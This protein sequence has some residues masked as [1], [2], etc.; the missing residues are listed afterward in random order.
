MYPK[1]RVYTA[2]HHTEPDRVPM[3]ASFVPE[4]IDKLRS[5]LNISDTDELL[6]ELGNDMVM[7]AHGFAAG[8]YASDKEEYYDDWGCKWKYFSNSSGRYPE[9]VQR[10]LSDKSL[11]SSYSIPDPDDPVQYEASARTIQKYGKENWIFG[12]IACTIFECAWGLRGLSELLLDMIEDKDFVHLLM[13]KV[14]EF[15]L[16]AGKKLIDMGVDMLW[17]G[18]DIGMQTGMMI[19]PSQWREFLKPRYAKLFSEFK[20]ADPEIILAYHSDG[21]CEEILDEMVEIGLNVINPIQPLCMDPKR[22]KRRYGKK[23]SIWGAVDIQQLMPFGTPS[24]IGSSIKE[25]INDCAPGGGFI[26]GPSHNIQS[27]T[28]IG[29]IISFYDSVRKYGI[30]PIRG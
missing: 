3:Y 7:V 5:Y 10:P 8:Y 16:T 18:D 15:P 20:K 24:Q 12:C 26:I 17:T 23:L 25:L 13:D 6:L 30:Y 29:N 14:M 27:E 9:I 2:L 4:A 19:S 21:N 1:E 11:I 22:I 28:S